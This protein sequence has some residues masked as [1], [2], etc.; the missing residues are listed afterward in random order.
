MIYIKLP[1]YT[2][3]YINMHCH[4]CHRKLKVGDLTISCQCGYNIHINCYYSQYNYNICPHCNRLGTLFTNRV[5][6]MDIILEYVSKLKKISI[7]ILGLFGLT[8]PQHLYQ[9]I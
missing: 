6:S 4:E 9:R 7:P 5:F 1:K 2:I 3:Y 8:V